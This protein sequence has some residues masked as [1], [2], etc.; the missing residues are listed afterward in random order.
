MRQIGMSIAVVCCVLLL[1]THGAVAQKRDPATSTCRLDPQTGR[2]TGVCTN[3]GSCMFDQ[4]SGWSCKLVKPPEIKMPCALQ[5]VPTPDCDK[6]W[7]GTPQLPSAPLPPKVI[8]APRLNPT[9]SACCSEAWW[10]DNVWKA[11]ATVEMPSLLNPSFDSNMPIHGLEQPGSVPS[12]SHN[13]PNPPAHESV[14]QPSTL[15]PF[16]VRPGIDVPHG[17]DVP[18]TDQDPRTF[19]NGNP[20]GFNTHNAPNQGSQNNFSWWKELVYSSSLWKY[21]WGY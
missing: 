16:R 15:D 21:M 19:Q 7:P 18:I 3:G 9:P 11:P 12:D 1:S 10:L 17:I 14:P 5:Q 13:M 6:N 2:A 8:D 20:T 4:K